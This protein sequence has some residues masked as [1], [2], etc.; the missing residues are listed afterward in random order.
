MLVCENCEYQ[1]QDDY[2]YCP[3]CGTLFISI[4][5]NNH[6]DLE[7]EGVCLICEKV[8]CSKCGVYVNENYLCDEHNNLEIYQ[9]MVR[10]YGS[11]DAAE[12]G[13]LI[14]MLVENKY[15]PI[16]FDRKTS[17]LSM[18]GIDYSLFRA[19]GDSN[20]RLVNEIK[21][22][23]PFSEFVDALELINKLLKEESAT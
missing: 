9:Q 1:V 3:Q 8:C 22:L 20:G 5:C 21:I 14:S 11:S 15:H 23:V 6:N 16:E 19:S 4:K 13:Y 7:G 18:G 2:D 10:V 17:P 12:I